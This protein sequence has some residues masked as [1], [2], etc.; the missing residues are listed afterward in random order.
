MYFGKD[1]TGGNESAPT[2]VVLQLMENLLKSG[3]TLYTDNYY[4]SMDLTHK[5]LEKQTH[6]VG[7]LRAN[8]KLNCKV[9]VEKQ[10]TKGQV[11]AKESN[12]GVVQM[13]WRDKRDV[14][15]LSTKHTNKMKKVTTSR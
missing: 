9:V 3:R 8:R 2:K 12:T 1:K 13:K 11:I 5:L 7:T 10:L 14:L 4:T 6:L 15:L